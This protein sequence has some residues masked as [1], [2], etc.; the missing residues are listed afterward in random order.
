MSVTFSVE[1]DSCEF[2]IACSCGETVLSDTFSDFSSAFEVLPTYSNTCADEFCATYP[3][4]I[5]A[6]EDERLSFNVSNTNAAYI[7]D[8]LG[9]V[10][11]DERMSGAM[12]ADDLLGRVLLAEAISPS[13]A[14]LPAF[15]EGSVTYCGRPA[16]Y[17]DEKLTALREIASYARTEKVLVVWG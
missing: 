2:K 5:V 17:L 9:V 13:D 12:P 11:E 6:I 8:A 7:F 4:R 14:G 10:D 16:G 15:T 1:Q 3:A